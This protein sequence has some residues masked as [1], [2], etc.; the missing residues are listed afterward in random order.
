MYRIVLNKLRHLP[1]QKPKRNFFRVTGRLQIFLL[2]WL[3][4]QVCLGAPCFLELDNDKQNSNRVLATPLIAIEGSSYLVIHP[5]FAVTVHTSIDLGGLGLGLDVL[6]LK[7]VCNR[8][9][10]FYF[11]HVK[12]RKQPTH[13][14]TNYRLSFTDKKKLLHSPSILKNQEQCLI[15]VA[16]VHITSWE[17]GIE[18]FKF[19]SRDWTLKQQTMS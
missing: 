3:R 9:L 16:C 7:L 19:V 4:L 10:V 6:V 11:F 18:V 12:Q 17:Q 15:V 14:Y 1:V 8:R 5:L 13:L 2:F